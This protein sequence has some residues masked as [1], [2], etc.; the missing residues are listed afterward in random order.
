MGKLPVQGERTDLD[1]VAD[2]VEEGATIKEI[3]CSHPTTFIKYHKGI[4]ALKA[5]MYEHRSVAPKVIWRWGLAGSGKTLGAAVHIHRITSKMERNGGTVMNSNLQSSLT[6]STVVGRS[7]TCCAF[8]TDTS[9]KVNSKAVTFRLTPR[10]STL[11]VSF[12][13][14]SS[15][16]EMN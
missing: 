4:A 12:L 5:A 8:L 9:I 3:A 14:T 6:I 16:Q 13:R 15:G 1:D 7:E 2:L 10:S 11:H